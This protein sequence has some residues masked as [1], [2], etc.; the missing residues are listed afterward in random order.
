MGANVEFLGLAV[1]IVIVGVLIG[2]I[3]IGGVLLVPILA[4]LGDVPVHVAIAS[5]NFSY[6]FSGL[7]G[8]AI[9]A[10]KGSISW[11]MGL[12]LGL[13]AMPA[14]Y[15][16]AVILSLL[17]TRILEAIIAFLIVFAGINA[18]LRPSDSSLE[19][20]GLRPGALVAIGAVVGLGSTVSGTGGPLILVP[21][22]TWLRFPVL[23]AIGLSQIIQVPIAVLATM[24]NLIHGQIDFMLGA[25]LA[26]LLMLGAVGGAH[27]SHRVPSSL[28]KRVVAWVL[29]GV[30]A[31]ILAR[32][33]WGF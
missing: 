6:L 20:A 22:L 32:L 24:G 12:W 4:Y 31:M 17:S 9:Y 11:R 25:V 10:R 16:G 7:V 13:G 28:L 30:G 8:A 19:R 27:L 3:G 2:S 5:C 18:I 26:A 21:L 15:L 1:A 14:A 29:I 33:I 23:V